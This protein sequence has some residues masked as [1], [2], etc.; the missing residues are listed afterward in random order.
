MV[1]LV[2]EAQ[3]RDGDDPLHWPPRFSACGHAAGGRPCE[4]MKVCT[5][6]NARRAERLAS[7]FEQVERTR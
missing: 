2:N 3:A 6:S 4:F 5:A 1:S 7:E